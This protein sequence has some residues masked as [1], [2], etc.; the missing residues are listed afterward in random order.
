VDQYAPASN[1]PAGSTAVTNVFVLEGEGNG[2]AVVV[3][4]GGIQRQTDLL[5]YNGA[6]WDVVPAQISADNQQ[7]ITEAGNLPQAL[8]VVNR[9]PPTGVAIVTPWMPGEEIPAELLP[10]L[11]QVNVGGYTLGA[12]GTLTAEPADVPQ[13][14]Y[15]TFMKVSNGGVIVDQTALSQLLADSNLQAS[16]IQEIVANAQAGN[17]A[18]VLLDYQGAL[19]AQEAS[20]TQ[21]VTALATALDSAGLE[22]A[23]AVATPTLLADGQWDSG[24]QNLAALAPIA[25]AIMLQ[26]P[27]EPNAYNPGGPAEQ[28]LTWAVRQADRSKLLPLV[29]AYAV[30]KFG[31]SLRE[32]ALPDALANLG[33]LLVG[34]SADDVVT[35]DPDTAVTIGFSGETAPLEWDGESLTYKFTYQ[36]NGQPRTVWINNEAAIANRLRLIK[37]FGVQWCGVKWHL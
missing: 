3:V 12:N 30:D 1:L 13:G 36:D 23:V 32:V 16:H 9:T 28:V 37:E 22:L 35:L 33:H 34:E 26:M 19:S 4:P 5:G 18:G 7:F 25:D 17:Y 14:G 20:Y 31:N 21:F 6:T 15:S 27:L 11:T 2:T 8:L 24:G 29:S 10:A